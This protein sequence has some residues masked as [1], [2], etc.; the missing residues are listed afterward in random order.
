LIRLRIL[1]N[2]KPA[3]F[4]L[5]GAPCCGKTTAMHALMAK[6]KMHGSSEVECI[7][8]NARF[9]PHPL[10]AQGT[11]ETAVWVLTE[12]IRN[13]CHMDAKFDVLVCDR[14]VFDEIAFS[15]RFSKEEQRFLNETAYAWA[16]LKP[17]DRIF[18][19]TPMALFKDSQRF[20]ER[21]EQLA[22][23]AEFKKLVHNLRD[24]YCD[25]YVIT[26]DAESRKERVDLVFKKIMETIR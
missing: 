17:Y 11:F 20:I 22:I 25:D 1:R 12:Q 14:S 9:C 18:F 21:D 10:N 2:H 5:I 26:I 7:Y 6:L 16:W 3:K 4:A 13:E 8:E 24:A 19:L 15:K 23:H